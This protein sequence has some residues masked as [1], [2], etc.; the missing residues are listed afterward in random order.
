MILDRKNRPLD[1][2]LH[3]IVKFFLVALVF[4][5]LYVVRDIVVLFLFSIVLAS[6]VSKLVDWLEDKK[7]PRIAALLT[8]AVLLVTAIAF[9]V[10]TVVPPLLRDIQELAKQFPFYSELLLS[11]LERFGI[12][13]EGPIGESIQD[14][15]QQGLS[16]L[17]RGAS[18]FP[19]L[20][21]QIAGGIFSAGMVLLVTF[22]L[23]LQR[24]GVEQ[25]LGSFL[26][27]KDS[28][29]I[30]LWRR[31]QKK[32]G[33]WARG[34]VL[35]MLIVTAVVFVGLA[36]LRV[37]YALLLALL[38]GVLELVPVVGPVLAGIAAV[39]VALFDSLK[40]A[41]LV[42]LLFL[43]VQFLQNN[44]VMP[45]LYKRVLGLHPVVIIFAL[46]IGARLA[47][48]IGVVLSVPFAA[49]FMEFLHDY[50]KG[51]VKL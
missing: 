10:Y 51:K 13:H 30:S 46:L 40:L 20:V 2:S 37:E 43:V 17:G 19:T 35:A 1:I 4:L 49:V 24:D 34:Q 8:V 42:G 27:H 11:E 39:G 50:N 16:L 15:L 7:I 26:S 18:Y 44:V 36:L 22:Y 3:T 38:A 47:G 25:L 5:F 14:A 29:I 28:Y 48:L 21:T 6:G 31:A 12:V 9:F 41:V 32:I 45:L 23:A 33:A